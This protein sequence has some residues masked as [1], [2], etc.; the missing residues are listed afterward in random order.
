MLSWGTEEGGGFNRPP[1]NIKE[2]LWKAD[3]P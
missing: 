2:G 3:Y 1:Q